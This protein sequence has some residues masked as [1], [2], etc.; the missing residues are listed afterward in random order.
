MLLLLVIIILI[1]Y[2]VGAGKIIPVDNSV[3]VDIVNS[4]WYDVIQTVPETTDTVR[5]HSSIFCFTE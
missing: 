5:S 2:G 4:F 3:T 1:I